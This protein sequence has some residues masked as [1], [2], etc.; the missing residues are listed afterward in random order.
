M[1]PTK[2]ARLKQIT[3]TLNVSQG[4]QSAF[5]RPY[6]ILAFKTTVLNRST[7]TSVSRRCMVRK[8]VAILNS[9]ANLSENTKGRVLRRGCCVHVL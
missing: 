5:F 8:K 4:Y 1:A 9:E 3:H 6:E 7:M 2:S